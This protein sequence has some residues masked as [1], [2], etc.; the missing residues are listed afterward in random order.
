M[1]AFA[2]KYVV[3]P[4]IPEQARFSQSGAGRDHRLVAASVARPRIDR[5]QICLFEGADPPRVC[6]QIIDQESGI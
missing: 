6:L 2:G 3:L 4:S 1:S 5:E